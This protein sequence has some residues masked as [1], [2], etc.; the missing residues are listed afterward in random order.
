MTQSMITSLPWILDK[1]EQSIVKTKEGLVSVQEDAE[2]VKFKSAEG[3]G[4]EEEEDDGYPVEIVTDTE[5]QMEAKEENKKLPMKDLD[6][7]VEVIV[8]TE[9]TT[10]TELKDEE[11]DRSGKVM[12]DGEQ[13]DR[14]VEFKEDSERLKNTSRIEQPKVRLIEELS[15]D[16][17]DDK[18][19]RKSGQ[20]ELI[21]KTREELSK[22]EIQPEG[23]EKNMHVQST[24][25][26]HMVIDEERFLNGKQEPIEWNKDEH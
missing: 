22:D 5:K 25:P 7:D 16:V 18:G 12:S 24:V 1:N 3:I 20:N 11:G 6:E 14:V 2:E 17:N 21:Y 4:E 13:M 15:E 8:G 9:E 26:S 19:S 10:A 23:L